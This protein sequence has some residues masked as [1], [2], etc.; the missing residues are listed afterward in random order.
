[1]ALVKRK[2]PPA[3]SRYNTRLRKRH[4]VGRLIDDHAA[5]YLREN[6]I[7][8]TRGRG[9]RAQEISGEEDP[10]RVACYPSFFYSYFVSNF[11]ENRN[12]LGKR[13]WGTKY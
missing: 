4:I 10:T 7:S 9:K 8:T 12:I 13:R 5:T 11:K 6:K 2:G 3:V 1:M